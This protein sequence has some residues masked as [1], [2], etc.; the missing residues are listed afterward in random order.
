MDQY[1]ANWRWVFELAQILNKTWL[2]FEE[3]ETYLNMEKG[4]GGRCRCGPEVD[5]STFYV[6]RETSTTVR[7]PMCQSMRVK[8]YKP[9]ATQT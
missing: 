8:N 1:N 5:A 6:D 9:P 2:Y 4:L 3:T 7:Y